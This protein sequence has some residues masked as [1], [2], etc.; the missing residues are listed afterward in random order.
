MSRELELPLIVV[1]T[2]VIHFLLFY[3]FATLPYKQKKEREAH[4]KA[5][6]VSHEGAWPP[7]PTTYAEPPEPEPWAWCMQC[8][9][10]SSMDAVSDN[11]GRCGCP[12]CLAPISELVAWCDIK[13]RRNELP[14]QPEVGMVYA[15]L[16]QIK[17][18]EQKTDAQTTP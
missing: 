2:L 7:A 17:E 13:T 10:A 5:S 15:N 6:A 8:H 18:A 16:L 11:G 14:E 3:F 9:R 12:E 1:P 4:L